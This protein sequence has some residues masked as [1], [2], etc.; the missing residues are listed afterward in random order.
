MVPLLLAAVLGLVAVVPV[1]RTGFATV[2]GQNGDAVLAVGT[3]EF[4]E[5][6]PPTAT[7][8]ELPLDRVPLQWRSKLPIYYGLAAVSEVAG[9]DPVVAFATVAGFVYALAGLGLLLFAVVTLRAPPWIGLL[10]LALAPLDRNLVHVA[11]HPFYNQAWGLLALPF[12]VVAGT[13]HLR[14]PSP[15]AAALTAVFFTLGLFAYPLMLPFP[16]AFLGTLAVVEWRRARRAGTSVGW[17][18][19]LGLPGL[20]RRWWVLVP[21]VAIGVPVVL[22]LVRGV[23][24]K[25]SGALR[26]L[27][28]G[29]DLRGWSGP[30]LDYLPFGRFFGIDLP[31]AAAVPVT[32][33]VFAAG[34]LGVRG[35]PRAVQAALAAVTAAGLLIAAYF[36]ARGHGEL[37]YFKDLGF[38]GPL[39]VTA[40][41]AGLAGCAARTGLVPAGRIGATAALAAF[42]VL[43][44][45]GAAR[46]IRGTYEFATADLL[47]LRRWDRE[48]PA[49]AS[50]RIDVP[51]SGFQLWAWY[52]L[53][54]HRLSTS[55]P[56]GGF[57]PSPPR[58]LKADYVLYRVSARP[59]DVEAPVL[60]NRTYAVAR[61]APGAPGPDFSSRTLYD[62]VQ[63]ITLTK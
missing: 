4:L 15:R 52:F 50:I 5:H 12:I 1:L 2:I 31:T 26:V 30:A 53:P 43:L 45:V 20:R 57:F 16:A 34:A 28:P 24:E 44:T 18:S 49:D 59:A 27:L 8:P 56:L 23:A 3:A 14:E 7:R 55:V 48:L 22:T 63:Q 38:L 42:V 37:F 35:A 10:V 47:E 41:I 9:Q 25:L 62:P 58:G 51:P 33:L 6:A 17:V 61:E 46:E 11:I 29:G 19:A 40:A 21:A 39:V 60:A 54:R 36:R 13:L 32:V